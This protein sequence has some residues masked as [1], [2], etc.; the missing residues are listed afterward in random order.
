MVYASFA[1]VVLIVTTA[2]LFYV[3]LTDLRE[4]KIRNELVLVLAALYFLH[5]AL[6]G[7]WVYMHWNIG[8]AI[9]MFALM[10][11]YYQHGLMGGGDVKMLTVAFLWV[12][13]QSAL[14]F[15][16]ALLVFILIHIVIVKFGWGTFQET[17]GRKRIPFA[18]SI[19]A[20]LI[21][22]FV[23]GSLLRGPSPFNLPLPSNLQYYWY[24]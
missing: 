12:G 8:F 16:L 10:V 17:A 5:A 7:R 18:P 3:A 11:Y 14:I 20:A 2:T 21:A 23:S 13:L 4:F 24:W 19:A 1:D 15:S 9:F 6:S 22:T